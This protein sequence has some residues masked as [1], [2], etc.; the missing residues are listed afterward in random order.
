MGDAGLQKAEVQITIF[1]SALWMDYKGNYIL[2]QLNDHS[3]EDKAS[4]RRW[5]VTQFIPVFS[6]LGCRKKPK[7]TQYIT[8]LFQNTLVNYSKKYP[9]P[10][11]NV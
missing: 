9:P 6:Q 11:K 3:V 1:N 2:Q 5:E 8:V 7:Q 4:Q 10:L